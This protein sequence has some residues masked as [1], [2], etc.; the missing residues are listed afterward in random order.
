[1]ARLGARVAICGRRM[2]RLEETARLI[3]EAGG[4]PVL[5]EAMSI[6]DPVAVDSFIALVWE[7]FGRVDI[8]VNNAGGQFA[9]AA[10]DFSV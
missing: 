5:V 7:R 10:I 1:M 2:E 8:L 3:A 6:R 4:E 9:Q